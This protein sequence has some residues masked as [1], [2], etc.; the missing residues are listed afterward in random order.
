VTYRRRIYLYF[1]RVITA[2]DVFINVVFGGYEDETISARW[3]RGNQLQGNIIDH[4]GSLIL[5]DLEKHH[6]SDALANDE[7]R[8]ETIAMLEAKARGEA[9]ASVSGLS[10]ICNSGLHAGCR[11]MICH[12][13]CHRGVYGT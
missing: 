8:A 6:G 10:P 3:Q 2:F 4:V 5:T 12:C 1:K 9:R 11:T 7:R 13:P